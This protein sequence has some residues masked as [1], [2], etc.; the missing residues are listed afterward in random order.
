[1]FDEFLQSS[2]E[3]PERHKSIHVWY[4]C[5]NCE[6]SGETDCDGLAG[7]LRFRVCRCGFSLT[8]YDKP[9]CSEPGFG[10]GTSLRGPWTRQMWNNIKS[11]LIDE[12]GTTAV[13]YAVLLALILIAIIGGL[14]AAGG[15]TRDWWENVG[16]EMT[17]HGM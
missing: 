9:A 1:M 16:T 11:F 4:L 15:G 8:N 6:R 10:N 12:S 7:W 13:E 3:L 2:V 14:T 17:N 5:H